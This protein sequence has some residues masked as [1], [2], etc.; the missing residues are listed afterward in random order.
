MSVQ[1]EVR[2]KDARVRAFLNEAGYDALVLTTQ[3]NFAW[4]TGGGDNHVVLATDAGVASAVIT[5]DAKYIVTKNNE[6]DRIMTEEVA[7]LGFEP[8]VVNWFGLGGVEG[9]IERLLRDLVVASDTG[10][11][12]STLEVRRIAE[13]RFSLT[14]EEMGKYRRLGLDAEASMNAVCKSLKPGLTEHEIAGRLAESLYAKGIAPVVLLIAADERIEQYRHPIATD[15]K[16]E[17]CVMLVECARRS[18]LVLSC[19]RIVHFGPLPAELQRRHNA[20]VKIDAALNVSTTVGATLGDVFRAGQIEYA[21]AGFPDEWR[22]HHQGGSAGYGPRDVVATPDEKTRVVANQAFSWNPSITG[23][24]SEDTI[25]VTERGIEWLSLSADWPMIEV[26][27]QDQ[28]VQ[29]ED[30]LVL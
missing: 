23:T 20:V 28:T 26:E 18:G 12:G 8:R 9:E 4:V 7:S 5:R 24:K 3:A 27:H 29:R 6:A 15:K 16:V 13:L 10:V 14:P 25:L 30:I 1:D 19:T 17:R 11:A 2:I 22:L 21:E